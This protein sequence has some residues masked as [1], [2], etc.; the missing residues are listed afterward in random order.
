MPRPTKLTEDLHRRIVSMVAGGVFPE[1][2]AGA[3]GVARATFYQWISR[4]LGEHPTRRPTP[5]LVA[6]AA[7]VQQAVDTAEVRLVGKL[8]EFIEGT[9]P[10]KRKP[11][12]RV[13][14]RT[15]MGQ[16]NAVQ[17][18]LSR[19]FAARW[20]QLP[21]SFVN[22]VSITANAGNATSE[23]ARAAVQKYFGSVV[24]ELD[25]PDPKSDER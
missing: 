2:A 14:S 15:T 11:G 20:A 13:Q 5:D 9:R 16:V 18:M 12:T 10:S 17:W 22:T 6:F 23:S 3:C 21:P 25:A 7:D 1:I 8:A 19:R 24:P 4:G